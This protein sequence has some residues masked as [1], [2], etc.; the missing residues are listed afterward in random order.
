MIRVQLI[1]YLPR[2]KHLTGQREVPAGTSV[3][4]LLSELGCEWD[5][6]ALVLLNGKAAPASQGLQSGDELALLV[7][8]SGG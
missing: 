4:G 6:A 2:L 8:L 7:P 1:C 3:A 5:Q